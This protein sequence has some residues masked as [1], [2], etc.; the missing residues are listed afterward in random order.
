MQRTVLLAG[1]LATIAGATPAA[2]QNDEE[3]PT[4]R[5]IH[6]E[7][8]EIDFRALDVR[9]GVVGPEGKPVFEVRRMQFNPMIELRRDF[10][11]AMDQSVDLVR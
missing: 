11:V 8:T 7:V 2:A 9:A 10:D 5:V 1:L 6:P 4:P 3:S